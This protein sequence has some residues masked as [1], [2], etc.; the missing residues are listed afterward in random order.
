ML[1]YQADPT[2]ENY[3]RGVILFGNNVASYKFALAHALYDLHTQGNDLISL[4]ALAR[5]F[6]QHLFLHKAGVF[7]RA[8]LGALAGITDQLDVLVEIS[9]VE[10]VLRSEVRSL[11]ALPRRIVRL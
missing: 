8:F 7:M 1:F 5:P 11:Q 6:S 10:G 3:W 4:E 2:L 9:I